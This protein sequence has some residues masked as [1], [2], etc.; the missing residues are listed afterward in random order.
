TLSLAMIFSALSSVMSIFM[1]SSS[2][3]ACAM[4]MAVWPPSGFVA[5]LLPSASIVRLRGLSPGVVTT[6]KPTAAFSSAELHMM[7]SVAKAA[8]AENARTMVAIVHIPAG[9]IRHSSLGVGGNLHLHDA[10]GIADRF[11]ALQCV[12]VLHA[13]AHLAPHCVLLVEEGC[14]AEAD[15]ELA[16]GRIRIGRARHGAH[17]AH[18]RLARELRL[19]IGRFPAAH[20]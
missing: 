12:D 16:V 7:F 1:P 18:M 2:E 11:A 17:A 20:A 6:K 8:A 9:P 14:I 10:V 5:Q 3:K 4:R 15:K 13:G 19:Q